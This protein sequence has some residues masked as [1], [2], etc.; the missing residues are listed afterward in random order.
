MRKVL[1]LILAFALIFAST[2]LV[3]ADGSADNSFDT[4][5]RGSKTK[6]FYDSI[7]NKYRVVGTTSASGSY[8]SAWTNG[9]IHYPLGGDYT[10]F[11]GVTVTVVASTA[12]TFTDNSSDF[13]TLSDSNTF[14]YDTGGKI[15]GGSHSFTGKLI[16]NLTCSHSAYTN[17]GGSVS[18]ITLVLTQ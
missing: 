7:G 14:N 4:E 3:F 8:G 5:T 15:V 2:A 12:V 9:S 16:Y 10:N 13:D 17:H 11:M 6:Y 1:I 18:F